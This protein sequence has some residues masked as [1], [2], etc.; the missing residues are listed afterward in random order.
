MG[1]LLAAVP[2]RVYRLPIFSSAR[3]WSVSWFFVAPFPMLTGGNRALVKVLDGWHQTFMW[4]LLVVAGL[5]IVAALVAA[6]PGRRPI[7]G[8]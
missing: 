7:G 1:D 3:G 6:E 5:H 4:A 2:S 8:K